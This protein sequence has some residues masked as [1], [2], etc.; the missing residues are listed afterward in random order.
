VVV[1]G[2]WRYEEWAA[3]GHVRA[4]GADGSAQRPPPAEPAITE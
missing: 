1:D 4:I 2:S 3:G